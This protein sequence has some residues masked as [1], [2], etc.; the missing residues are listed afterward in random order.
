MQMPRIVVFGFATVLN[1]TGT[2]LL[3]KRPVRLPVADNAGGANISL[4]NKFV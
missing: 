1:P 3:K 2:D 4:Q